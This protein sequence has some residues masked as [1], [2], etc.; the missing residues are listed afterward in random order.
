M[1]NLDNRELYESD[2]LAR[3]QQECFSS[4]EENSNVLSNH[5]RYAKLKENNEEIGELL[6]NQWYTITS[7]ESVDTTYMEALHQNRKDY[8][9]AQDWPEPTTLI[10]STSTTDPIYGDQYY[11]ELGGNF[12]VQREK[13]FGVINLNIPPCLFHP[14]HMP[15]YKVT[16]T[17]KI[18]DSYWTEQVADEVDYHIYDADFF[19]K[20]DSTQ[21]YNDVIDQP[22]TISYIEWE[23]LYVWWE[24]VDAYHYYN[25]LLFKNDNMKPW[26]WWDAPWPKSWARYRKLSYNHF[27][28]KIQVSDPKYQIP[29]FQAKKLNDNR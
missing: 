11:L 10:R 4:I 15:S 25:Y 26:R 23:V 16:L 22:A 17:K 2:E 9:I 1:K 12:F 20:F 29:A 3:L 24:E 8:I 19:K 18:I 28:S 7:I 13:Q 5:E 27:E 14:M 21:E 6:F